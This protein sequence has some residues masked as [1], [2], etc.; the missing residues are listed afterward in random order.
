MGMWS[1]NRYEPLFMTQ[2]F[3][4]VLRIADNLHH[5]LLDIDSTDVY[6]FQ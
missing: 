4:N 6:R 3:Y 5:A 1:D 2:P